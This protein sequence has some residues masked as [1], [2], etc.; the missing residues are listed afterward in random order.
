M[1]YYVYVYL[2]PR[3]K[4]LFNYG[5]YKF[6]YEPFYIGKSGNRGKYGPREYDHLVEAKRGIKRDNIYKF[7]KIRKILNSGFSPII[8]KLYENLNNK[9]ASDLEIDLIYS[10]GRYNEKTGPL[11][12]I[13][14]GGEGVCGISMTEERRLKIKEYMNRPEVREKISINSKRLWADPEHNK[15]HRDK[16]NKAI[17]RPES[18]KKNSLAKKKTWANKDFRDK[19]SKI[20]KGMNKGNQHACKYK[21]IILSPDGIK[22]ETT[23]M[24]KF[25]R[26]HNLCSVTMNSV[27]KRKYKQHKGWKV[28][29]V[30]NL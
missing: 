18:R 17:R 15:I 11:T 14:S 6:K 16:I 30:L 10:I 26:E 27:A 29:E 1:R 22:L 23:N 5:K 21:Y 20:R 24:A 3:K 8:Y 25:C 9:D 19:M 4:G 13:T 2:D 28:L 7:N 12:N